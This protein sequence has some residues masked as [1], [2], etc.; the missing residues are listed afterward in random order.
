M[1][2]IYRFGAP[3]VA[4]LSCA[5][6]RNSRQVCAA[7]A[8]GSAAVSA[9]FTLM[10]AWEKKKIKESREKKEKERGSFAVRAHGW[11]FS[12]QLQLAAHPS[13]IT[14]RVFQWHQ[15][16]ANYCKRAAW[17]GLAGGS[18]VCMLLVPIPTVPPSPRVGAGRVGRKLCPMA[19]CSH[20]QGYNPGLSEWC[21]VERM[22]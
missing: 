11:M 13:A 15:H 4:V 12:E 2:F 20:E 17:Q 3:L 14:S 9:P 19:R 8:L 22:Q 1:S 5:L 16:Q 21:W 10:R 7:A 18:Y 6:S